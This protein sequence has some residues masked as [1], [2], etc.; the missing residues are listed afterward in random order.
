MQSIELP[1]TVSG[2]QFRLVAHGTATPEGLLNRSPN[3]QWLTLTGY[4]ADVGVSGLSSSASAAVGRVV[5]RI[6]ATG[7]IDTSTRLSDWT[8]GSSPRSAIT[9]DGNRFLLA[10]GAGGIHEADLGDLTSMV[11]NSQVAGL[12]HIDRFGGEL[13]I[14]T[15]TAVASS[16]IAQINQ[17]TGAPMYLPGVPAPGTGATGINA[18]QFFIA[19]LSAVEAGPDTLYVADDRSAANGG[20]LRKYSR[21]SGTWVANGGVFGTQ[22]AGSPGVSSLRGLTGSVSG[23]TVSLYATRFGT[24]LIGFTDA[25]GHNGAFSGVA[26][27]LADAPSNTLFKGVDFVPVSAGPG[28]IPGDFNNDTVVDGDDLAQWREDFGMNDDSDA[29]ND[30]DSDGNDFLI[31]QRNLGE[32]GG[33]TPTAGAIP[34]PSGVILLGVA[35]ASTLR[36][37]RHS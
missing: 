10:G 37:R 28:G 12:R 17:T 4:D 5:G 25:T 29:D 16:A 8:S 3:G 20:G 2:N 23:S 27:L 21:V 9:T 11:Y 36:R 30:G 19:D 18:F 6:D 14:S 22:P 34:E 1:T 13:Y 35:A 32:G 24:S 33:A 26:T 15:G 31:W 7:A